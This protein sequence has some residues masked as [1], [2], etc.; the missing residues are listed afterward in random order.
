MPLPENSPAPPR[1]GNSESVPE[2]PPFPVWTKRWLK[3]DFHLH[4]SEDPKDELDHSSIEL[5]YRAHALGFDALA[6]TLHDHVLA[7]PEVFATARELGILLIPAAEMRLEGAD[8]VIVNI[9]EEETRQLKCLDDLAELRRRR[10]GSVLIFPPHPFFVMGGSIGRRIF[11]YMECFDAIEFSHFYT[12]WFNLNRPALRAAKAHGKPLIAASDT[13]LLDFFGTHYTLVEAPQEP[14][15]EAIFEAIRA[16][17]T[18]NVSEP[19]CASRLIRQ[20]WWIFVAH[21]I[22]LIRAKRG[23]RAAL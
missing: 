23:G 15:P 21:K 12:R 5:L 2:P 11:Q 19:L 16:G 20:L 9:T 7:T 8:V 22:K 17:R 1:T 4:A 18:Q 13:H 14:G 10:G 3:I 6:I